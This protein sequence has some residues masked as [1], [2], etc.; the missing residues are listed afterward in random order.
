[1]SEVG[2]IERRCWGFKTEQDNDQEPFCRK[3]LAECTSIKTDPWVVRLISILAVIAS[4]STRV[5]VK[6][7]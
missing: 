1:M 6:F 7:T 4:I 5:Q 3:R 2:E